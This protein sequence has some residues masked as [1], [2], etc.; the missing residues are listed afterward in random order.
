MAPVLCVLYYALVMY[1]S[2]VLSL[3]MGLML[4]VDIY[5]FVTKH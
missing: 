5:V 1:I 3:D 2:Y 4:F